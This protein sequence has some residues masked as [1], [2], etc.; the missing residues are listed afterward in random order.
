[1]LT[2]ILKG[3]MSL[4]ILDILGNVCLLSGGFLKTLVPEASADLAASL[5]PIRNVKKRYLLEIAKTEIELTL[6][7]RIQ[8][9]I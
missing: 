8:A 9:S 7:L 5:M 2:N 1:M 6:C 3:I 4:E